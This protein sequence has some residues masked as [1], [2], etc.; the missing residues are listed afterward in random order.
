[1]TGNWAELMNPARLGVRSSGKQWQA[2]CTIRKP[3][4]RRTFHSGT[5]Q[6]ATRVRG[7]GTYFPDGPVTNPNDIQECGHDLGQELH[8]LEP[9]GLEDE[10][11][12]LDDH[13]VVVREGLVSE[14]AHQGHHGHGWV[15]LV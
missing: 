15:K 11:D 12:G 3:R 6:G 9:Q 1:M 4:G 7:L 8:A 14:D 10:G 5:G 2:E 13:G